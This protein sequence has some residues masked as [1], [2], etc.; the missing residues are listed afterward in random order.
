[1]TQED[2]PPQVVIVGGGFSGLYA[3]RALRDAPCE[4]TLVDRTAQHVFQPLLYQCATGIL[5]EGQITAPL[6]RL[7]RKHHNLECVN[8]EAVNVD[9]ARRRLICVRPLGEA[10]EVPYDHLIVAAG[11]R[12][13]YFGHDEFAEWAPGM[14]TISDALTIRRRVFGAFEMAETAANPAEQQ[15][16]LTFALVGAGPTGVELAG[17]IRELATKTLRAEFRRVQPEDARVVLFDGGAAPLASFGPQL[18]RQATRTLRE[19]GVELRMNS[20]VT[21]VDGDGLRARAKDGTESRLDAATVLWTAG[22]EAPRLAAALATAAGAPQDRS[23]RISV[24]DNLTITGHPE[25]SVVGDLMTLRKLPGLAEVAMQSGFYAGHRVKRLLTGRGEPKPFKYHDLGSAAY[26]SRGRAV[27]SAGPL[28]LWGFPGW[29]AWLF[30][31]IAFLTGYRN[32]LGAILTWWLTFTRDVRRERA[33]TTRGVG[34]VKDLYYPSEAEKASPAAAAAPA[35]PTSG[36][37]VPRRGD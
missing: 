25:I 34:R 3:A 6:R 36:R 2:R 29:V 31:H 26:V 15:H 32:R 7:F 35:V 28:H 23:G 14:K 17:Q 12:Q 24:Q 5:S 4:V 33:Y 27:V 13:S 22:V 20:I 1:M 30:I 19:L 10:I 37:S 8:A 16:W 21:C 11:L 9:A 18:S